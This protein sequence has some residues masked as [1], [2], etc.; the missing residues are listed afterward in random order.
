MKNNKAAKTKVENGNAVV[1]LP[2][3]INK[4]KL[5]LNN[6][7]INQPEGM[8][9]KNE[10]TE[11]LQES[12]QNE[13]LLKNVENKITF[14]D[15]NLN[16]DIIKALSNQGYTYPTPI[17]IKAIPIALEGKDILA[18]AET[19]SGKTAAFSLPIIQRLSMQKPNKSNIPKALILSPTRELTSQIAN[20]I[21]NYSK[22]TKIKQVT[23]YGGVSQ[24]NQVNELRQNPEIVVATPGRLLDLIAQK[25]IKINQIQT[26]V[27][28]EADKML[29]MGFINDIK[30][31][32]LM[33]PTNCQIMMFSA[34]IPPQIK[35]LSDN[36][37]NKP[38]LISVD[39]PTMEVKTITSSVFFVE[40]PDKFKLLLH[41]IR[42]EEI[43]KAIVFS[44]TKHNANNIA[45]K[46]QSRRIYNDVI[47]GNKSQNA[48]EKA[49]AKFKSGEIS[50]LIAT[51]IAAR[52]IDVTDITHVINYDMSS[53][54]ETYLHRIG[55]TARAGKDGIAYNFCDEVERNYLKDIEKLIQKHLIRVTDHPYVSN[56]SPPEMTNLVAKHTSRNSYNKKK[57]S[58]RTKS[59][60]QQY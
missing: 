14:T 53:E 29:D 41:L 40:K 24:K 1:G 19:G 5:E 8:N 38:T 58:K 15:L 17:Q 6:N 13:E 9:I 11:E 39:N 23:I 7:S 55:R 31:I 12:S 50:V 60:V 49:L 45:K 44:R 34:T 2:Q 28:D 27:L 20:S 18:T 51:D 52:G 42:T 30:K 57:R 16:E 33:L 21:K 43:D 54:A 32:I 3:F 46:L 36:I 37:L 26:F 22:F 25:Y 10:I 4:T 48:R 56:H 59:M 35:E 47:H